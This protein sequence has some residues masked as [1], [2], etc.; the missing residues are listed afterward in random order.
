M[1]LLITTGNAQYV[2][3]AGLLNLENWF[4]LEGDER[5]PD[6]PVSHLKNYLEKWKKRLGRMD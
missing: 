1:A 3:D 5:Y 6:I 4:G 2:V